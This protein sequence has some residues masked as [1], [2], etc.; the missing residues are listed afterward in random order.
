MIEPV[1]SENLFSAFSSAALALI[2][3]GAFFSALEPLPL[4]AMVVHAVYDS[5]VREIKNTNHPAMAWLIAQTFGNFFGA[6]VFG[7]MQT[8]PQINLHTHGTQWTPSHGHFA[9]FGAY[10]TIVIAMFYIALQKG[11]GEVWMGA[12]LADGGWKWKGSLTLMSAGI[13]GMSIALMIAGYEQSFIERAAEG[14]TWAGYFAAQ[15]HPWFIQ[16]MGWRMIFGVVTA[17]GFVLLVWDLM[18]IGRGET[19]RAQK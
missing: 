16:G 9:F 18:T 14:S 10:A 6:G 2:A 13:V 4:V 8:L 5:G 15:N 12:G 17:A 3:V 1:A 11:R 19:R 7:F